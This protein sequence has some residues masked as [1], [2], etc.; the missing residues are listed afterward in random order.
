M[1]QFDLIQ[2]AEQLATFQ[3]RQQQL[4]RSL[5][6]RSSEM[7]V[8]I[9]IEQHA[10]N[11]TA[12]QIGLFLGVAKPSVT[13]IIKTLVQHEFVSATPLPHDQR[14]KALSLT[15]KGAALLAETK[16][17]YF[18]RLE[19]FKHAL[20]PDNFSQFFTLLTLTNE[21]FAEELIR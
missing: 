4:N 7:G 19:R 2:A 16:T 21:F 14:Q 11:V 9:F 6:I 5:P 8:L 10:E 13:A 12:S 1:E 3:R 15:P 20:G 18:A 17:V